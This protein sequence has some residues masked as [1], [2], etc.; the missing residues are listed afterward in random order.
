MQ[1]HIVNFV[2]KMKWIQLSF[3]SIMTIVFILL[4]ITNPALR[5]SIY[6]HSSLFILFIMIWIILTGSFIFLFFDFS[7]VS[8]LVVE[9]H[10]L[11]KAAFLDTLTGIPNRYSC[12][13][14]FQ[15]Y[16][17]QE[18]LD[19]LGCVLIEIA[20]LEQINID[21]GREYGDLL[22]QEFCNLLEK[23]G[24][25][26]GFVG[27]NGGNEFLV[28]LD[29]CDDLILHNFLDALQNEIS[30]FNQ[31]D[32]KMPDVQI[33]YEYVLNKN[34]KAKR[35]TDLITETYRKLNH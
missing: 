20:N 28:I 18:Q 5:R 1:K 25:S 2:K 19:S 7:K 9:G 12:D 26:Y 31:T 23:I 4:L 14:I 22:I 34:Y 11:N 27:R 29:N 10:A 24:D 6:T 32:L 35:F 15:M 8:T 16:T 3:Y 30:E 13:T 17:T 33:H 21:K